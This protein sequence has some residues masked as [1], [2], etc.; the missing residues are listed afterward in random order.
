MEGWDK[1][2][3]TLYE[4]AEAA[5]NR[6]LTILAGAGVSRDS[7]AK[8]PT[9]TE[10]AKDLYGEE[11]DSAPPEERERPGRFFDK[12]KRKDRR[13]HEKLAN[14]VRE[15]ET[16]AILHG[17]ILDLVERSY[18]RSVI[19]TNWDMLMVE[20]AKRRGMRDMEAWPPDRRGK[21]NG[22]VATGI[23]P[24]HGTIDAPAKML[25]TDAELDEHYGKEEEREFLK[26]LLEGRAILCVG[27][28]HNDVM[29]EKIVQDMRGE[30]ATKLYSIIPRGRSKEETESV[31]ERLKERWGIGAIL[32][33]NEDGEH[34]QVKEILD[35]IQGQAK[36]MTP[37]ARMNR[38]E[39]IGEAGPEAVD[40]W[41][42]VREVFNTGG[43][44]LDHLLRRADPTT[45][46][47]YK[48][49][50][51]GG[52]EELFLRRDTS[53]AQ[54]KTCAWLCH[55]L[56]GKRLRS[57]LWMTH[58]SKGRMPVT[59]RHYLGI[60][61]Q[62]ENGKLTAN[63]RLMGGLVLLSQAIGSGVEGV[64]LTMLQMVGIR[65]NRE[66]NP[67]V[68]LRTLEAMSS[69]GAIPEARTEMGEDGTMHEVG[70]AKAGA[71]CD[72]PSLFM[73]WDQAVRPL[74]CRHG[75]R[76]WRA[77]TNGL[78]QQQAIVE[79]TSGQKRGWNEWSY[80]RSA[81]EDHEQ[82]DIDRETILGVLVEG[83][84]TALETAG[85][86]AKGN[87]T[88]WTGYI[89]E[90][91][92]E[93]S[94]L[95][96][97]LA[98]H[99]VTETGH[100]N[101]S[102]KLEWLAGMDALND[103]TLR[104]EAY[105]LVR[106]AWP[107]A[108]QKAQDAA[109]EAIAAMA[110]SP[111][112]HA[113][114]AVYDERSRYDLIQWL[115][116]G[117]ITHPRLETT[118]K[119]IEQAH[120]EW[121]P[122]EHPDFLHWMT[123]G[124]WIGPRAPHG[125]EA[126]TLIARWE[127]E[128]DAGLEAVI[129]GRP[130]ARYETAEEWLHG[131]NQEGERKAIEEAIRKKLEWGVALASLL[132]QLDK[133]KHQGWEALC[134][135]LPE[136]LGEEEASKLLEKQWWG[137]LIR[138]GQARAVG[139]MAEEAAKKAKAQGWSQSETRRL[140]KHT[141]GWLEGLA[142]A[143]SPIREMDWMGWSINQPGGMAVEASLN[144]MA[145]E[146]A[147]A[148]E[149]KETLEALERLWK[150]GGTGRKHVGIHVACNTA[151][152]ASIDRGWVIR[153][154]VDELKKAGESG[155]MRCVLWNGLGYAQW[156]YGVMV[157]LLKEALEQEVRYEKAPNEKER[158]FGGT[159]EDTGANRFGT[160]ATGKILF[161]EGDWKE[162]GVTG[163]PTQRRARI[164]Q[165]VCGHFWREKEVPK[166][167]GWKK[168][169][170]PLWEEILTEKGQPTTDEQ[171]AFLLC[172]EKLNGEEAQAFAKLFRAGPPVEPKWFLEERY[173]GRDVPNR[174]AAVEVFSHCAETH[175]GTSQDKWTWRSAIE[176]LKAWW[177]EEH[178]GELKGALKEA[179]AKVGVNPKAG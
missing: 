48:T 57:L 151:W 29:I 70:T 35:H 105:R 125:W 98:I 112:G 134:T 34:Q 94:V 83:A 75:D 24:L 170:K 157:K 36:A 3:T 58:A 60:W 110:P 158:G 162:W 47:T 20:A 79:G 106:T 115:R 81:I 135:V 59:L 52:L 149:K 114:K 27:Y 100:W 109:A 141:L 113:Q 10:L 99:G 152:L 155:E 136:K 93:D 43:G 178:A 159:R 9:Y 26:G 153:M 2:S 171:Q 33:G 174:G 18:G 5:A 95:L 21:A 123:A 40:D 172:F 137:Y 97:R 163:V 50:K 64:D 86:T 124:T 118:L 120:P 154:V 30:S 72:G 142:S 160:A 14:R 74:A 16:P 164:V 41:D 146:N 49:L 102:R 91:E 131:P 13:L 6:T 104:H 11:W 101:A 108:E 44:D 69:I 139:R 121:R 46:A 12:I 71:W 117:N 4:I 42:E 62:D 176:T 138:N 128:G 76:I 96:R 143:D 78:R 116:E 15:H 148:G 89:D 51:Q 22:K 156:Q 150:Q 132:A 19:T 31:T 126:S 68:S 92:Q 177:K 130:Q 169:V 7:P 8:V 25:V 88:V 166:A 165:K 173:G 39:E 82:D 54:S 77:C 145:L 133:W 85:D 80:R 55:E 63:E 66:G 17:K 140:R 175:A 23:I 161:D 65:C 127:K 84:R 32:Y 119:A 179:L 144:L 87:R 103:Y 147:T 168:V 61:L 167:G 129:E 107:R 111:E 90:C 122:S 45:W 28:S 67:E 53:E 56:N 1:R 38:L 37:T 73:F